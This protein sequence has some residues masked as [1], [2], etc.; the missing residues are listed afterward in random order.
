ETPAN[1]NMVRHLMNAATGV[2][3]IYARQKGVL[4]MET[5]IPSTDTASLMLFHRNQSPWCE[6]PKTENNANCSALPMKPPL[7]VGLYPSAIQND[8]KYCDALSKASN[9]QDLMGHFNIVV[10]AD[11]S[12]ALKTAPY[13]EVYKDDMQRVANELEAAA[14]GLGQDES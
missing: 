3:R 14:N 2:E 8:P 11:K 7:L 5:K 4:D 9:A 10:D 1:V 6:A 12:G 13:N